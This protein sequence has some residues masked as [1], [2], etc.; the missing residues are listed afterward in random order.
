MNRQFWGYSIRPMLRWI[1][2]SAPPSRRVYWHDVF[3]SA[4]HM[5]A[6]DRLLPDGL[7]DV[8]V[9]EDAVAA[10]DLGLIVHEKHFAV[11][12]GLLMETYGTTKPAYVRTREGVPIVT[13]YRR[14]GL[15]PAPMPMPTPASR[16]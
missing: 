11:Y 16:P 2:Q 15:P 8:G 10:S 9:G 3:V 5:Y 4:V 12:E 7:G 14:P 6:A 13:A 1:A